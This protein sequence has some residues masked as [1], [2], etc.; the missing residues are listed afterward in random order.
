M[1]ALGG[2]VAGVAHE[3]NTPLGIGVTAAS[4]LN[5]R[6]REIERR[7]QQGEM[8]RSELE[9][10]LHTAN[11]STAMILENL[12]RAAE[13]IKSFKQVAVD[14]TYDAKRVFTLKQ[15]IDNVLLSL[16]PKLKKTS[17]TVTVQCPD[18]LEL[19]GYPGALSQILTILS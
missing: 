16:H 6:S 1:A 19:D 17:H 13:N 18:N 7:Y 4:H 12:R 5:E 8:T 2:L 3:I 10:Y 9:K 11:K 14:Q 15:C